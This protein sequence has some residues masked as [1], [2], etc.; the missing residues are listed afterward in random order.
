MYGGNVIRPKKTNRDGYYSNMK[1]YI[2]TIINNRKIKVNFFR[3]LVK[4]ILFIS[5]LFKGVQNKHFSNK[6][7]I[8]SLVETTHII[9]TD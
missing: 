4:N 1:V 5:P 8:K 7:E 3:E 6:K 2:S 9:R